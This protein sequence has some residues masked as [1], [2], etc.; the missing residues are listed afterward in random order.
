MSAERDNLLPN[1][2]IISCKAP[3]GGKCIQLA[4]QLVAM[5]RRGMLAENGV[6]PYRKAAD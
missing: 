1:G 3:P 5:N 6:L 4:I 2:R